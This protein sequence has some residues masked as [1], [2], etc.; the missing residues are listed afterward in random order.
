[1]IQRHREVNGTLDFYRYVACMDLNGDGRPEI[2][3]YR[4]QSDATVVDVFTWEGTR[5]AKVLSVY[6]S[7]LF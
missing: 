3:L 2:V 1:M 4:A 5:P 7:N 6:K